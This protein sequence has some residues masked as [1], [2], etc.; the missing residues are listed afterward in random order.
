MLITVIGLA[1]AAIP[2]M[3]SVNSQRSDQRDQRADA[4][5]TAADSGAELAISRQSLMAA[6]L[7]IASPCVKKNGSTLEAVAVEASGWC[8]RVPTTGVET[9]GS[10]SFSYR[11]KPTTGAISVVSTGTSSG[12]TGT[13]SRRLLV[14]AT[15]AP[16]T[17]E[18]FGGET[19]VGIDSVRIENGAR[20]TGNVGSN[21]EVHIAGGG[22]ADECQTVRV[23]KPPID[24]SGQSLPSCTVVTGTRSYPD[25]VLPAV[26]SNGRMFSAGGDTYQYKNGAIAGCSAANWQA[27]W[28]P[29]TGVLAIRDNINIT[30]GGSDPYVFCQLVLDNG[31]LI[32]A[33]KAKVRIIFDSPEKCNLPSGT[34]QFVMSNQSD[35]KS[36]SASTESNSVVGLYFVGSTTKVTKLVIEGG[37]HTSGIEMYGP[38]TEFE[39]SNGARWGGAVI[40]KTV[41]IQGGGR[42]NPIAK[43]NPDEG[44]PVP[45]TESGGTY[46]RGKYIECSASGSETE[47]NSGC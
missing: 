30:L 24:A 38:H 25:V 32:L 19:L 20:S 4:S 17:P 34:K 15:S 12:G 47:P 22:R 28:C 16:T 45:K 6:R 44:L 36:E 27:S 21:G 37:N 7:T 23:G 8:P 18:V 39:T 2:I 26:S 46:A 35:I 41:N 1:L 13:S 31:N 33:A 9:V 43:F 5:L 40:A 11:V 10:G 14:N 42:V 3:A 29:T